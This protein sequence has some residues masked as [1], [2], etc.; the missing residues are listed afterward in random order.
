MSADRPPSRRAGP[1]LLYGVVGAAV[2]FYAGGALFGEEPG[3]ATAVEGIPLAPDWPAIAAWPPEDEGGGVE[4][5]PDPE[6]LTTVMVL[7]DSSSMNARMGAAKDAV[8]EAARLL[9]QSGRLGVLAL[10]AGLVQEP[11][12]AAEAAAAL[13]SRLD[14][15]RADGSTPLGP[16]LMAARAMLEAE[17]AR[18]RGF[19]TYRIIVATDGAADDEL[20]LAEAVAGILT[21]TPIQ[22]STIGIGLGSG[23]V[24]NMPGHVSYVGVTDVSGLA[25]ALAAAVAEN[26]TFE[27]ITAF[28]AA[29]EET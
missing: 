26:T 17:A 29:E 11:A 1:I 25:T 3:P 10:N 2:A 14:P 20:R 12:P 6:R 16:A 18:Q 9:P 23:H 19:G 21:E 28:D 22:I 24:L 8:T 5:A 27:P 13:P 7:D 4:A 15:I